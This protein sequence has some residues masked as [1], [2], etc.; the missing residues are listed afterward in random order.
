MELSKLHQ[1]KEDFSSYLSE[2]TRIISV[3][4]YDPAAKMDA[5]EG[6]MSQSL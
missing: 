4:N 1:G 3:L 5:L 6:G 2:F